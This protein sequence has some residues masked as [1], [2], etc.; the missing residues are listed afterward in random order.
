M[1]VP[2]AYGRVSNPLPALL[3]ALA[4]AC[5]SHS[6]PPPRSLAA[7]VEPELRLDEPVERE[8]APGE[9]HAYRVEVPAGSYLRIRVEPRAMDLALTLLA[10]D[11]DLIATAD[12][13][14]GSKQRELLTLV[15]QKSGRFRLIV[16]RKDQ[17]DSRSYAVNLE[18]RRPALPTDEIRVRAE[19]LFSE[20][21]HLQSLSTS[22][23]KQQAI[24]RFDE[25]LVL[26]EQLGDEVGQTECLNEAGLVL[27]S[28]GN[29]HE[30]IARFER[31]EA[32]AKAAGHRQGEGEALNNLGLAY[33]R[34]GEPDKTLDYYHRA[35]AIWRETST[36]AEAARTLHNLGLFHNQRGEPRRALEMFEEALPL[37]RAAGELEGEAYTLN[38]LGVLDVLYLGE[39][40]LALD[41]LYRALTLSRAAGSPESEAYI[42]GNLALAHRTRGEF[43]QAL[44]LYGECIDQWEMVGDSTSLGNVREAL[45]GLHRDLGEL[46]RAADEYRK[47]L[48]LYRAGGNRD[49]EARALTS[50]GWVESLSDQ[51]QAAL[52]HH[53]QALA[54][55]REIGNRRVEGMAL[56]RTGIAQLALGDLNAA[57]AS[58]QECVALRREAGNR[59]EEASALLD[60]GMV[61]HRLGLEGPVENLRKSLELARRAENSILQAS[62]LLRWA[63]LDREDGRL[64]DA[65]PR[66]EEALAIIESGRQQVLSRDLRATYFAARREYYDAY[67]DLLMRLGS[68]PSAQSLAEQAFDASERAR[69]RSLLELLAEG[70]IDVRRGVAPELKE[71]ERQLAAKISSTQSR[72]VDLLSRLNAET[73]ETAGLRRELKSALD[74]LKELESDIRLKHPRYA[75]VRYP[76]VATLAQVQASLESDVA[77][78][79]YAL[80]HDAS[81][82]FVLTRGEFETYRLPPAREIAEEVERLRRTL[83]SPERRLLGP[84]L[85]SAYRLY[86]LLIAPAAGILKDRPK[87]VIVADG[88]L[89]LLPFEALVSTE[90]SRVG[91]TAALPCLLRTHMVSYAPSASVLLSLQARPGRAASQESTPAKSLVAFADP[92][93]SATAK[94]PMLGSAMNLA[95]LPESRREVEA[96][97]QLFA[98]SEVDLFLGPE[99][100]EDHVK[101]D[102]LLSAARR[103][104]FATHAFLSDVRP[105]LSGLVLARSEN[106][107]EDGLLQVYEIFNLELDAELIVLSACESGLGRTVAGE[108][109]I[110]FARAFLYAGTPSLVVSLWS[111]ED[112]S[113]ADLMIE[114]YRRLQQGAG[115]GEALRA[116]KLGVLEREERAHPYYWAPFVLLGEA[117]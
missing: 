56:H 21:Y 73:D 27:H 64:E 60:L 107:A 50:L 61:Q 5:A 46:E 117:G 26:W 18:A 68:A 109:L 8:L 89:H 4:A 30:A 32:L 47:V 44:R 92:A 52:N 22:Q 115:V 3:L 103:I 38:S 53:Q 55:S 88:A 79:E 67:I 16:E 98:P 36:T 7:A 28:Q 42:T 25:S 37:W 86:Q 40:R 63:G 19:Q 72:L 11:G 113:T 65:R 20:A 105:E 17:G 41:R 35:L 45:A 111:V 99:A 97:A 75:E 1:Q 59:V 78:L 112:A 76:P 90:P 84:Y 100:T 34:L 71:R 66:L 77:L 62:I 23:S 69:A 81:Y 114:F 39:T 43:E 14:G 80:G 116:A 110:G 12:G 106:S 13:P 49:F 6:G 24:S 29:E 2:R 102:R 82:L 96:I 51:P 31:A 87:L 70:R 101:Q 74:E 91:D 95:D 48:E 93:A 108:G 58:L 57:L 54:I 15:A 10:P 104:H 83:Q 9:K 85:S 33:S 94:V